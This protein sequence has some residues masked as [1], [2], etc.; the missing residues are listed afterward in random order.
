MKMWIIIAFVLIVAGLILFAGVMTVNG[1]DFAKLN[2]SKLV[3]N[4]FEID[5]EFDCLDISETT[6]DIEFVLSA[7]GKCR[8]ICVENEKM[9]H[10]SNVEN[11]TLKIETIDSR[12]W[13]DYIGIFFGSPKITVFLPEKAYSNLSI[14]IDTGDIVIPSDFIFDNIDI[15]GKTGDVDCYASALNKINIKL[16]T[17]GFVG[18]SINA[19]QI[20]VSTDTGN[21]VF[22]SVTAKNGVN[23]DVDTGKVT[24]TNVRCGELDADID[25]GDIVLKN[26]VAEAELKVKTS[27][28]DV[29]FENSDAAHIAVETS[30]GDVEGS[31]LSDKIFDVKTST[32]R[33]NIPDSQGERKCK[34]TTSTGD[35][36]ITIE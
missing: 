12:K 1:W 10:S 28:G 25:T 14:D 21:V 8:V 30:T 19:E 15:D 6:A 9:K 26:V 3:E 11:R 27:T 24:F 32:G 7:D 4:T 35:V 16:S 20:N 33:I 18:E 36:H 22:E 29:R 34:I 2:T 31:L 5:G 23:I 13:Y 17:G